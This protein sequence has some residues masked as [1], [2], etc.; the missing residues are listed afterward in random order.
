MPSPRIVTSPAECQT[1]KRRVLSRSI[2]AEEAKKANVLLSLS[3]GTGVR[4]EAAQLGCSTP[5]VQRYRARFLEALL[6]GLL[7]S[8][9]GKIRKLD[10]PKM[11]ARAMEWTRRGPDDCTTH[12]SSRRLAA[13]LKTSHMSLA[14]IWEKHVLQLDR[15]RHQMV[16]N[17]AQFE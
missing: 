15:L 6:A 10:F 3:S 7:A 5:Y 1:L 12:W 11:E 4:A 16:S 8:H 14:R 2:R 17:E 9:Q 13:R